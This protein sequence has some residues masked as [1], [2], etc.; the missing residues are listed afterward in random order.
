MKSIRILVV[1]DEA[2]IAED[3]GGILKRLGYEVIEIVPSG[4]L[5]V[6]KALEL[7]PDLILM[8]IMLQGDLDG[9]QAAQIINS[10]EDIPVVFCTAYADDRTLKRAQVTEPYG[11]ILKPFEERELTTN[12]QIA[13]YKHKTEKE[14]K[15]REAWL[16]TTLRSIGDAVISTDS[17]GKITFMNSVAESITG[18]I[19]EFS[20]GKNFRKL[21][22]IIEPRSNVEKEIPIEEIKNNK[23][24]T[25]TYNNYIL[26]SREENRVPIEISISPIKNEKDIIDGF[27][28]IFR[29]ATEKKKAEAEL[30]KLSRAVEQSHASIIITDPDGIVEYVNSKYIDSLEKPQFDIIGKKFHLFNENELLPERRQEL[31]NR[32]QKGKIWIGEFVNLGKNG[33]MKWMSISVSPIFNDTGAIH[34]LV[35][36]KEDITE[37]KEAEEAIK[38]YNSELKEINDSKD[39][40]FSIVSHDLRSPFNGLLGLANLMATEFDS[41]PYEELKSI[42]EN[43][44]SSA[45]HLFKYIENLLEWSRLQTGKMACQPE[46][47]DLHDSV[48]NILNILSLN[49]TRKN[50]AV[51]YHLEDDSIVFADPNMVNSIL[52][53]LVSNAIKFTN[54]DG[55]IKIST[56]KQGFFMTTIVEDNGIGMKEEDLK[57]LFTLHEHH[58][59][60]GTGGERGTG[61][62]LL[63]CKEMVEAN[64]GKILVESKLGRG[65]TFYFTLPVY[66]PN[67]K[68][69]SNR[70]ITKLSKEDGDNQ[71]NFKFDF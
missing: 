30:L 6:K 51:E 9:I 56:S 11:Y 12:I 33:K 67:K 54:E 55:K 57:R 21:F 32:I 18:W 66:N 15:E 4:Q 45:N 13:V 26:I 28:F 42:A 38:K 39:K 49:M 65:T 44:N 40:F 23:N 19:Q 52:D 60:E 27:V 10:V 8:D 64:G 14:I 58:S 43:L 2:I 36:T 37:R 5:A 25:G 48:I 29:D 3:L 16:N 70:R 69:N 17:D 34:N 20:I 46:K 47:L 59:S 68:N 24:I 31:K 50:I 61:L 62:G 71:S 41:L 22:K 53:N 63:I 35:I 1:E 7:K